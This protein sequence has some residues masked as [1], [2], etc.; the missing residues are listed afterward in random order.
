[1]SLE[2]TLSQI[3]GSFSDYVLG[4]TEYAGEQIIH[5]KGQGVID[6]LK[7]FKD[8]GFNFLA[9]LTAIDNLTL[10][11]FERFAVVYHLLSHGSAERVTIKAY[12][13]EDNPVLPSIELLWKTADWQEREVFDLFGIEFEGHPNLT[14]IM[15]P[16]DYEGHPLRKDY[17]RL[18]RKE[19]YDFPVIDRG[20]QKQ[21]RTE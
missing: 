15:N 19:R 13:P 4:L 2:K 10:G 9:D 16:D 18:G 20:I 3:K 14:R 6:V 12:V 21:K 11:G 7:T 5:I 17:P 1:M 8:A